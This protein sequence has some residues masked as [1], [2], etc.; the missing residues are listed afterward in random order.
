MLY[1]I[2]NDTKDIFYCS[3]YTLFPRCI[4]SKMRFKKKTYLIQLKEPIKY[5]TY[6]VRNR[7]K[8]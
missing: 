7:D 2:K 4:F 3:I 8:N 5:Y 6:K 1:L